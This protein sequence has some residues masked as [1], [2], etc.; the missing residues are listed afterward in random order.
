MRFTG[1]LKQ[2]TALSQV[3]IIAFTCFCCPGLYNALACVASGIA[4]LSIAYNGTSILYGFFAVFGLVAG[5]LVN[6]LGPKYTLF[7]GTWGYVL[8]AASLLVMDHSKTL[9]VHPTDPLQNV[10]TYSGSARAFYYLACALLGMCAGLLWTAQGQMCMAYPTQETKGLYFS[11]FWI[12]YN[13]GATI[14]GI[15]MFAANF[16]SSTVGASTGTYVIFLAL[17]SLGACTSLLLA[18]PDIV[19]RNDDTLVKVEKLPDWR[20]EV[21]EILNVFKDLKMLLLLPLFSYSN[22]FY[23]Y[24]AY[25]NVG[26]F[27]TRSGGFGSIFYWS[28]QIVGAFGLGKYLDSTGSSRRT[29]AFLS[30]LM[31]LV[32]SSL[33]WG[34]GLWAQLAYGIP[35]PEHEKLDFQQGSYWGPFLLYV[36]F[37]F[38]DAICQVWAFWLM[39]QF[40]DDLAVLG[41]YAGYYYAVQ[42][43]MAAVSWKI[44]AVDVDPVIQLLLNWG[45]SVLGVI[46]AYFSIRWYV[47]DKVDGTESAS[48]EL[49]ESP[50]AKV[51]HT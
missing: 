30:L 38:N 48:Y 32:L 21:V 37:G 8:Y 44:G 17:T 31:L 2:P 26:L 14:G 7:L 12:V 27:N 43:S 50:V 25:F 1:F 10:T 20:R 15:V 13:L 28:A 29:R 40:S 3:L 11:V 41:R 33:M 5:G 49:A 47:N 22:W 16:E 45:L 35:L 23:T 24:H 34:L 18:K 39:G 36:Y 19:K 4:D 51:S 46:G 6:L 9:Y 42:A